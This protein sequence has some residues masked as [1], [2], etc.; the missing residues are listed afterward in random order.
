[1]IF[2][3]DNYGG[4]G[5]II[6]SKYIIGIDNG[7]QSTKVTIF[8]LEGNEVCYGSKT[9]KNLY[10]AEGGVALHP[11]DDLWDSVRDGLKD[12]LNK[13]SGNKN[14]IL[15]IGLCT[16]RCCRAL[17]KKDGSLAYP[18]LSW[19]DRRLSA[20][21]VH[22]NDEVQYVTTTSGYLA[23]RMTGE[24]KD[25]CSNL[26]V[27]WPID[28]KTLDWSTDDKVIKENGLKR[29]QL[30]SIIKP[31]E[32]Y[33]PLKAELC[34]E[35]GLKEGIQVVATGN[36]K[37]VEVLGSGISNDKSIMISLG[38][39]ISSMLLREDYFEDAK[40]FFPTLAC[41]PFKYVYE[42]KGI[43]RGMWTVSWYKKLLGK[44]IIYKA[45]E[46]G[47]SE[48]EY[49]NQIGEKVPPGSD[50][51]I[52]L[53]DWL[54]DSDYEFRKGVMLGFDHRHTS[55]HIYRSILEAI[56]YNIKNNIYEM[57]DEIKA[58]VNNITVIGGG[59]KSNLMMQIIGDMFGLPVKRNKATSA[60][61]LGAAICAAKYLGIYTSFDEAM[62][63]MV[64]IKEVFEPNKNLYLFYDEI[65]TKI[66]KNIRK[67]TDEIFK[68]THSVF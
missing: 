29:D 65:N 16:I 43:R 8:D 24:F 12:C 53:L 51:L 55:A 22:E 47:I 60:A 27:Y 50:G 57:L 2:E 63:K 58:E 67:H 38:T 30:F 19:M 48:E 40:S 9:L 61:C 34:E 3:L 44:E 56:S 45:K 18:V 21:Y 49:L 31:G 13:F 62:E 25:T 1:M 68:I 23:N 14:S 5:E 64:R 10:T 26:E 59:S 15:A 20:P 7:S 17:L 41:E 4:L 6:M 28:R 46:L 32:N 66:I 54:N 52:T 42:S 37:A 39:F 35:F 33:G 11:D 36:D